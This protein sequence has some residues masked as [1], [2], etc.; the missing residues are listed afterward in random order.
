MSSCAVSCVRGNFKE[1]DQRSLPEN[2]LNHSINLIKL[3]N[4]IKE[5]IG[6]SS[7]SSLAFINGKMSAGGMGLI[8]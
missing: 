6:G 8:A 1:A 3:D 2:A 7:I 4:S 5:N